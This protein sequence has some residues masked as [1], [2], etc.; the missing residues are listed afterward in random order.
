MVT[1][2]HTL[3]PSIIRQKEKK[4]FVKL[5]FSHEIAVMKY[6]KTP[7]DWRKRLI[8]QRNDVGYICELGSLS[9]EFRLL[10]RRD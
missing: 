1:I 7:V 5:S 6:H 4:R 8:K 3:A 2:Y 9:F 10:G